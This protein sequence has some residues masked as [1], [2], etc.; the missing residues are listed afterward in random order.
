MVE[1]GVDS[2]G[3]SF[4]ENVAELQLGPDFD[5]IHSTSKTNYIREL[6]PFHG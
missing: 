5:D 3:A 4:V 2:S 6:Y 1:G